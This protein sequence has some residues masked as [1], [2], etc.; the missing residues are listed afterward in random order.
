MT[1]LK[2]TNNYPFANKRNIINMK[3]IISLLDKKRNIIKKMSMQE[4]S[5]KIFS[6][7]H[8]HEKIIL[9]DYYE[10]IYDSFVNGNI[11]KWL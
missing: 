5:S 7:Y 10:E 3:I 9:T 1:V 11:C 6:P 2:E 8:K 4:H